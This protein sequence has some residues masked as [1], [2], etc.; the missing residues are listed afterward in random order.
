MFCH[1]GSSFE[2]HQKRE[3]ASSKNQHQ[4][5]SDGLADDHQHF[6][7]SNHQKEYQKNGLLDHHENRGWRN[8][9]K[10]T[11]KIGESLNC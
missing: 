8:E 7:H 11:G 2:E 1:C 3:L 6:D 5:K 9:R 10:N 4:E